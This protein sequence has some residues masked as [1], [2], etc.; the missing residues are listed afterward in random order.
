MRLHI[1]KTL[2]D[3]KNKAGHVSTR[4]CTDG[5]ADLICTL[6]Q[7]VLVP[8]SNPDFVGRSDILE[9]V[10]SHLGPN[11]HGRGTTSQARLALFGLGGIGYVQRPEES[12]ID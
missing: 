6:I 4:Y 5:Y 8:D 9:D 2:E 7:L 10:K 11:L 12:M 1:K 3:N